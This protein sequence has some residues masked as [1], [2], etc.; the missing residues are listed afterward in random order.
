MLNKRTPWLLV[1]KRTKPAEKQLPFVSNVNANFCG[2][3]LCALSAQRVPTAVNLRYVGRNSFR[4][5]NYPHEAGWTQCH[6]HYYSENLVAPEIE[7]GTSGYVARNS[8][9]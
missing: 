8:D 6:P 9:H 2:Y 7:H 1:R 4:L 5:L 3:R